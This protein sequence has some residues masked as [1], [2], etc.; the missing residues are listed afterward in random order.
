MSK[1][2]HESASEPG[3][4]ATILEDLLFVILA[5]SDRKH[6]DPRVWQALGRLDAARRR[7]QRAS[8][9]EPTKLEDVHGRASYDK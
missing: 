7:W 6:S 2:S 5:H 4:L 3:Q 1:T 9:A 8:G